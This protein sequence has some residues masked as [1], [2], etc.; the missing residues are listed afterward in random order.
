MTAMHHAARKRES[1]IMKIL[2]SWGG[3][4]DIGDTN[5][6]FPLWY[7]AASGDVNCVGVLL[8]HKANPKDMR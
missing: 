5:G 2:L 7:A 6:K 3:R 8:A 4:V 1:N